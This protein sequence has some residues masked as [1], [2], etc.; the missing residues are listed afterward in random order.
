VKRKD[1]DALQRCIDWMRHES[2]ASA[3]QIE[4]KLKHE[5]FKAAGHFA[6]YAVQCASLRLKPWEAP[7]SCPWGNYCLLVAGLSVYEP[8]P[9]KAL[10]EAEA[11]P[12]PPCGPILACLAV[13]CASLGGQYRTCVGH[14]MKA[15]PTLWSLYRKCLMLCDFLVGAPGLE[16]GTR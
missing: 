11:K 7:P 6:A 2:S 9:T 13:S 15:L 5:G 4:H 16:P 1:W 12:K 14:R 8:D 3:E 10:A